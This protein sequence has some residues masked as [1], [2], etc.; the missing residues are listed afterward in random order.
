MPS[1]DLPLLRLDVGTVH[2]QNIPH[3]DLIPLQHSGGKHIGQGL[4]VQSGGQSLRR[5][6]G[7]NGAA[8]GQQQ[9]LGFVQNIFA[10][11]TQRAR[12]WAMIR[13]ASFVMMSN[14]SAA[15]QRNSGMPNIWQITLS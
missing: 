11:S 2:M 15:I 13:S 3:G 8:G 4:S 12:A 5:R 10:S 7:R 1:D 9:E 14:P 6:L